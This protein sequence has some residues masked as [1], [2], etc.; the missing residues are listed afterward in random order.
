MANSYVPD[1][2]KI[3]FAVETEEAKRMIDF[4]VTLYRD[5]EHQRSIN[6]KL[7]NSYNG[8][9]NKKEIDAIVKKHG[10]VSSTPFIPY[11]IGRNKIKQLI[12]EFLQMGVRATVYTINPEAQLKKYEKYLSYKGMSKAKPM[13]EKARQQGLN[14]YPG[15]KI[16]SEQDVKI[17]SKLF[18]STNEIIMQTILNWKLMKENLVYVFGENWKQ[19]IMTSE[20]CGKLDRDKYFNDIFRP[21]D[22]SDAIYIES[23]FDH[24]VKDSFIVGERRMMFKHQILQT[25]C[26]DFEKDPSLKL[27]LD[28]IENGGSSDSNLDQKSGQY[29]YE[30][31]SFQFYGQKTDRKKISKSKDGSEYIKFISDK[32]WKKDKKTIEKDINKGKYKIVDEINRT[33]IFEGHRIGSDLYLGIREKDNNIV[34][35][36]DNGFEHV[37]FDYVFGLFNT[38]DGIR[39][40]LQEIVYEMEKVYDA[41]RRQLN[42]EISKLRGSMA[43]F[44]EAFMTNK[45]PF[46]QILHDLSEHGIAKM[47]SSVE[48][49]TSME[50]GTVIDRFVREFKLGDSETI[51]TLLALAL[52]IEQTLD[53]ITGMNDDRQGLGD[54]SSTATTNQNNV[55]ASVSMTYDMFNFATIYVNEV[56]SRLVEKVKV[57]WTWLENNGR[58]MVLSDEEYGY[59]VATKELTNDS[60]AS[61]ITDGKLEFDMRRRLEQ[62]FMAEINANK[63]RTLDVAKFYNEKSYAGSLK[64]L[65]EAYDTISNFTTQNEQQKI[66]SQEKIAQQNNQAGM[67]MHEDTQAHEIEK[68]RVKAE[69]ERKTISMQKD[70]DYSIIT[71]Q[72]MRDRLKE[73][74]KM[75]NSNKIAEKEMVMKKEIENSKM[76]SQAQKPTQ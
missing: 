3:N 37:E 20:M 15:Y 73:A 67:E 23:Y 13:I 63:L 6:K 71:N 34:Y 36:D 18:K 61:F 70:L 65:Q 60:Y 2:T 43:I 55:N 30:V 47:N 19:L 17:T 12:G 48:G 41:I 32:E 31:F 68:L 62:F 25:F 7:Y 22:P 57:N 53:R 59:L 5:K 64:V 9:I 38:V 49:A 24:F 28:E 21:I 52:D 4:G 69:E 56:L 44:D 11:R 33:T 46:T 26:E 45:S 76:I 72:S 8:I 35:T 50:E 29:L 58:G 74:D 39:I 1:Y 10:K 51:K 14:V 42:L 66:A 54:A 16:P 27:R 75:E 40:P